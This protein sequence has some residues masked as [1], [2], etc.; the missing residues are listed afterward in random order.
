M[1]IQVDTSDTIEDIDEALAF[2]VETLKA[3][4]N[5]QQFMSIVDALLDERL[6]K[7]NADHHQH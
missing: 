7:S 5:P 2:L 1:A 6:E 4:S 3:Q